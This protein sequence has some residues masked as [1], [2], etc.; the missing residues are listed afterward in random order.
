MS[1][2]ALSW[3]LDNSESEHAARLVLISIANHCDKFGR[4]AWP[5]IAT[6]G[7]E[8]RLCEREVRQSLRELESLGELLTLTAAG[9][10]RSNLYSLPKMQG[11]ENAPAKN[12]PAEFVREGAE[13]VERGGR[14]CRRNKEEPSLTVLEPS[15]RDSVI[16]WVGT[17][18]RSNTTHDGEL[19]PNI[20]ACA[21]HLAKEFKTSVGVV[22]PMVEEAFRAHLGASA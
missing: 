7:S 11:A 6:I 21:V 22:A 1:V 20:N 17:F 19:N 9:P 2:Q 10:R 4:N 3:V 12:A 5:T 16:A 15:L 14:I 18:V 8:A 13:F